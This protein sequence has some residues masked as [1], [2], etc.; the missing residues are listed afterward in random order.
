MVLTNDIMTKEKE[1]VVVTSIEGGADPATYWLEEFTKLDK[2]SN[3][4]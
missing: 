1:E 4:N 3:H 2:E